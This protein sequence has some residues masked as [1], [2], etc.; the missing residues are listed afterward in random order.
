[1]P[2]YYSFLNLE[3]NSHSDLIFFSL[4]LQFS[5]F[6]LSGT[7]CPFWTLWHKKQPT[8]QPFTQQILCVFTM[9]G[10]VHFMFTHPEFFQMYQIR[11]VNN[12]TVPF[13]LSL[14]S[15]NRAKAVICTKNIKWYKKACIPLVEIKMKMTVIDRKIDNPYK[16]T[17]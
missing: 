15:Q 11:K 8:N 6:I 3:G 17:L 7:V 14:W 9:T 1:M 16:N 13:A 10:S 2:F 5:I 4:L 12:V